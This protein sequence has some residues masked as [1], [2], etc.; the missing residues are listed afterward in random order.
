LINSWDIA[1]EDNLGYI[2]DGY[3][4]LRIVNLTQPDAPWLTGASYSDYTD[5]SWI[6]EI[7]VFGN[8]A[9]SPGPIKFHVYDVTNPTTPVELESAL[10]VGM[11]LE[12]AGD[13]L[14]YSVGDGTNNT[15]RVLDLTDPSSP[16]EIRRLTLPAGVINEV[17]T[18][19]SL[20]YLSTPNELLY[21]DLADPYQNDM[22]SIYQATAN[23]LDFAVAYPCI[24]MVDENGVFSVLDVANPGSGSV[25]GSLDGIGA[26]RIAFSGNYVYLVRI[27]EDTVYALDLADPH[28]PTLITSIGLPYDLSSISAAGK[29]IY[30]TNLT[31]GLFV[32]NLK[33]GNQSPQA[34]AGGP[35]AAFAGESFTLDASAS[36]DPDQDTLLY[37]WDLDQDG[38]YDDASGVTSTTSFTRAGTFTIGLR[39]TDDGGLSDID[40]ASATIHPWTLRGFYQPVDMNGVYNVAK[41][42]RTIPLK[43]EIFVDSTE[44]TDITAVQNLTYG[45]TACNANAVTDEIE[46]T[47]TGGTSLRYDSTEGQFIYNWK[48]PTT[49]GKCYR[50]TMTSMDGSSLVAFFSLK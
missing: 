5:Y 50:V 4:G 27:Y 29:W 41:N 16:T 17:E 37:E 21:V 30:L 22:T 12:V 42:G 6:S 34:V 20:V 11:H 25:I 3:S 24:Y 8:F 28:T 36:S 45:E 40:T 46:L 10:T 48:T 32:L 9:Y 13:V 1:L 43:F 15:L 14:V 18:F 39:V 38:E 23:L 44:L 26:N 7:T 49:P 35:Y 31:K 47:A 33:D 19:G 2:A